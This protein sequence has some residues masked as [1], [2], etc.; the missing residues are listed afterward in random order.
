MPA[1]IRITLRQDQ[2]PRQWYNIQAD[3]PTPMQPPLHPATGKPIRPED[4]API[5]PMNLIE[6]EVSTERWID[7]PEEVLE[8]AGPLAP[9]AA[10]PRAWRWRRPS[11]PRPGSTTRTRA[12]A[13]PAATSRTPPSPRPTTT[14]SSASSG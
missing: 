1:P 6:Q 12:S 14:S 2:L 10:A 5:F 3:L 13:R 4:L 8:N 7:I 9:L 11:T